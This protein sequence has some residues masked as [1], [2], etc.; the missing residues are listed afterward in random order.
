MGKNYFY[1]GNMA[2]SKYYH[3]RSSDGGSEIPDSSIR[4]YSDQN[5]R[6]YLKSIRFTSVHVD[7]LLLS[8]L[9]VPLLDENELP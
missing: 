3:E 4:K 9:A 7:K 6:H 2:K 5:I 8:Y 1:L